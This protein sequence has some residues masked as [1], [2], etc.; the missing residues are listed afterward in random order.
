MTRY[1]V[2]LLNYT[3]TSNHTHLLLLVRDGNRETLAKFMQ[4]LE[5]DFAQYYNLRKKRTGA[6]WSDRYHAV[7]IDRAEY[8]WNCMKY[9]DLNMVRAGVVHRPEDW[10]WTG[11]HEIMGLKRRNRLLDMDQILEYLGLSSLQEF[12]M[13]YRHSIEESISRSELKRDGKW[14]ESLAVG[15]NT[16]VEKVARKIRNRLEVEIKEDDENKGCWIVREPSEKYG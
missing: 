4:S 6:F 13:N 1:G 14:T 2:F 5:G 16:F 10:D 3:I 9:I 15:S 8:A 11:Y 12:R 7:M